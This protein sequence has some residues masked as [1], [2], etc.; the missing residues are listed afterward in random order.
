MMTL[1]AKND[2]SNPAWQYAAM[3]HELYRSGKKIELLAC[4]EPSFRLSLI[5][6]YAGTRE[7]NEALTSRFVVIQMP[8]IA[9]DGLDLSLIHI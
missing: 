5:H 1:C 6:I 3:R 8:P 2:Y 7:L 9:E 4:F